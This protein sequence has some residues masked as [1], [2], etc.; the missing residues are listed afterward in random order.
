MFQAFILLC[1][2]GTDPS[3]K[4]CFVETG[5]IFPTEEIC[6]AA[7]IDKLNAYDSSIFDTF[8]VN[9]IGCHSYI[10]KKIPTF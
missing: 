9:D 5:S 10:E 1:L 4:N 8:E 3:I 2:I 6:M 7:I